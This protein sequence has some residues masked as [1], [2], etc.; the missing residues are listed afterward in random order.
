M[1]KLIILIIFVISLLTVVLSEQQ[2]WNP[3]DPLP[4]VQPA[5]CSVQITDIQHYINVATGDLRLDLNSNGYEFF[6]LAN[7]ATQSVLGGV[8]G[9]IPFMQV[10]K[11]ED[12]E[13]LVKGINNCELSLSG[14]VR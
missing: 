4:P 12:F 9:G 2:L 6:S 5:E 11:F 13:Q 8:N 1:L 3:S 7:K 10:H 14:C